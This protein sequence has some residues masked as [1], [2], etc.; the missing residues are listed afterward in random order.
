MKAK[1]VTVMLL[2]VTKKE[3]INYHV[4]FS[5]KYVETTSFRRA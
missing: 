4:Q 1:F 3:P 2:H 5:M